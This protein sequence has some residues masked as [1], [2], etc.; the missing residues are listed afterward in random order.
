MTGRLAAPASSRRRTGV[1]YG[2]FRATSGSSAASREDLRERLGERVER[3]ARL[4]LGRLDEQRLV[5]D[6]REVDRRRV[7]AVVE[8][9]LGEVERA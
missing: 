3:L 8:Q 4:G 2:A 1:V 9:A 7:K 6:Q 5:D